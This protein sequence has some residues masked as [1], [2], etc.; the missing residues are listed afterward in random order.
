MQQDGEVAHLLR[1]LV[2]RHGERR[3]DAER[4]RRHD[5]GGDDGTIDEVVE[6]VADEHREDAA[7]VHFAVVSVAVAPEHQL[8]ED[9]ERED[10]DEQRREHLRRGP[11]FRAPSAGSPSIET[12]SSAPT[13]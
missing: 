11:G 3:A 10:A 5:R 7:V 6:G 9:E 2:C 8:L 13:A 4:H 12:P 1:N